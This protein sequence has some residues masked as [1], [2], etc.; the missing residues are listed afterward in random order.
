MPNEEDMA[1]VIL[2]LS[3]AAEAS[4]VRFTAITPSDITPATGFTKRKISITFIGNFYG[5]SDFLFR[6]RNL[7][8]V[9]GGELEATGRLFTVES[10]RFDE[11]PELFPQIEATLDVDVYMYGTPTPSGVGAAPA[12][13]TDG[14]GSTDT[15]ATTTSGDSSSPPPAGATAAG[16]SG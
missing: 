10:V 3:R 1:G 12:P 6:L 14:S 13:A 2:Q 7:V 9:R 11:A 8:A 15:G 4:G 5:L 16:V